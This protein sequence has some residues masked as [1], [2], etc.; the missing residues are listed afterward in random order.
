MV[1]GVQTTPLRKNATLTPPRGPSI[2]GN[3]YICS[4]VGVFVDEDRMVDERRGAADRVEPVQHLALDGDRDAE[5]GE[6]LR[7]PRP[8][9]D[10]ELPGGVGG[11]CRPDCD[12]AGRLAPF[13]D[14]LTEQ[15]G[16]AGSFG[17]VDMRLHGHL[18]ARESG[19]RL[20]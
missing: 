20:V 15:Q 6:Q 4:A 11:F 2:A 1:S 16:G 10:D 18:R 14:F 13:K 19:P 5:L 3:P 17:E 12:A 8:G 9:A 7:R